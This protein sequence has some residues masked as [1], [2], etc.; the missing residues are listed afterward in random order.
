VTPHH[1]PNRLDSGVF[2]IDLSAHTGLGRHIDPRIP[3]NFFALVGSIAAGAIVLIAGI[4]REGTPELLA[5]ATTAVA[6]FLAWA[7]ARELDPDRNLSAAIALVVAG[8]GVMLGAPAPGAAAVVL[9][10]AR[11][12]AGTVGGSLRAADRAVLVAVAAYAGTRP[13]AWA[14]ALLLVVAVLVTRPARYQLV[15]GAMGAAGVAAAFVSG[16]VPSMGLPSVTNGALIAMT[17]IALGGSL[18]TSPVTSRTDAGDAVI[19]TTR[20][21]AARLASGIAVLTGSLLVIDYGAV[22]LT[23]V[24]AA[25]VGVAVASLL[26]I[27]EP[28]G[29]GAETASPSDPVAT[30]HQT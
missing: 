10:M 1:T 23:P 19:G 13:E 20:V 8:L 29:P 26:P 18:R 11:I 27:R 28:A 24:I 22:V 4:V 16:A 12:L 15:A 3:S 5:P 25:L 2:G 6:V 17:M 9:L 14:A 7:I 21:A 30:L